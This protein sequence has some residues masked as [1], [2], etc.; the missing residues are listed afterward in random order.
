MTTSAV[1]VENFVSC[2]IWIRT[3]T[4]RFRVSF[5]MFLTDP[6]SLVIRCFCPNTHVACVSSFAAI[7]PGTYEISFESIRNALAWVELGQPADILSY[8]HGFRLKEAKIASPNPNPRY[9]S[10]TIKRRL[11][12]DTRRAGSL[13]PTIWEPPRTR[14]NILSMRKFTSNHVLE[15][16]G[17]LSIQNHRYLLH[18]KEVPRIEHGVF[19]NSDGLPAPRPHRSRRGTPAP[20]LVIWR[21]AR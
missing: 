16:W 13:L 20:G 1:I 18:K 12:D 17:P 15:D 21:Y 10:V 9:M 7:H 19:D 2:R 4:I 14:P 8:T 6:G 3:N 11:S 5:Y